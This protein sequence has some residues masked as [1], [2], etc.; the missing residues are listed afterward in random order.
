MTERLAD[1][2]L[3]FDTSL[4]HLNNAGLA[5]IS[6][7]ARDVVKLWAD[8][9][10]REGYFCDSAYAEQVEKSRQRVATLVGSP[11]QQ[12]AFFASTSVAVSQIAFGMELKPDD[13]VLTFAGEYGSNLYPWREACARAG[14]ILK[15]VPLGAA[16]SVSVGSLVAAMS[17][18]TRVVAVSWVQFHNGA[19]IDL[20]SLA[21]ECRARG[22]FLVVDAIQGLGLFEMHMESWG[23][24]AVCGGSHKWLVSPVGVGFMAISSALQARLRPLVVGAQSFGSCDDPTSEV[25]VLKNDA[26]R[27]ESGSKASMEIMALGASIELILATGAAVLGQEARRLAI[28]LREGL[29]ERGYQILCPHGHGS[30][31]LQHELHVG[32]IVTF[33]AAASSALRGNKEIYDKLRATGIHAVVR[34]GG[35]RLSPHAFNSDYDVDK[36]LSALI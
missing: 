16:G 13:E 23:V 12:V 27:F 10:Y 26:T 8:R 6:A 17:A 33:T 29:E 14:A 18:K 30:K 3:Q 22:I 25:C 28:R 7:V 31:T 11:P 24:D 20:K 4:I 1:F 2:K 5:P 36:A 21:G 34:G 9:F 35:I 32:S 15:D 19:M